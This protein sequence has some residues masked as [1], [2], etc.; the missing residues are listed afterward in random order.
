LRT[1]LTGQL[2][3]KNGKGGG[4]D[5]QRASRVRRGSQE[6]RKNKKVKN[7]SRTPNCRVTEGTKRSR[8]GPWWEGHKYTRKLK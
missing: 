5:V 8:F 4:G 7:P 2:R 1:G 3:V 6:V